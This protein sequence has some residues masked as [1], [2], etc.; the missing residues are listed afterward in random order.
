MAANSPPMKVNRSDSS[1]AAVE[2]TRDEL[3]AL[4][5]ALNEVCHGP[6]AIDE[7]EFFARMGVEFNEAKALLDE[8]NQL[9]P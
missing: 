9:L 8:V 1:G 7:V 6:D 3:L 5:N 4:N 2:L